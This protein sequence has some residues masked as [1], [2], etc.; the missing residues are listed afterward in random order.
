MESHHV[1]Q[2]VSNFL[3]YCYA[4]LP[5]GG[6]IKCYTPSVRPSV[7]FLHFREA[8]KKWIDLRQTKTNV[9]IGPS[10]TYSLVH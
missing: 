2:Q 9:I 4:A 8:Y 5:T 3:V 7:P 10:Y 6:H 1:G